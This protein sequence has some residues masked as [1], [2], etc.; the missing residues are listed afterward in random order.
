M[1]VDQQDKVMWIDTSAM[2]ADPM[3]KEMKPDH[4]LDALRNGKLSFTATAESQITKMK[5]QKSRSKKEKDT[6][7]KSNEQT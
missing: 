4:L 7:K 2:L 1:S 3:T 5:K 6:D